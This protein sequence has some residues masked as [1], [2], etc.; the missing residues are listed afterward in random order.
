MFRT[1]IRISRQLE[2]H[3]ALFA[4]NIDTRKPSRYLVACATVR[5]IESLA[6]TQ[7]IKHMG[8]SPERQVSGMML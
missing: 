4:N 7:E 6:A 2:S 5:L 1:N 8:K 3:K